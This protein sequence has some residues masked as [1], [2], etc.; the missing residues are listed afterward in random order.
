MQ[1]SSFPKPDRSTFAV[2]QANF[3]RGMRN[4][5]GGNELISIPDGESEKIV[6]KADPGYLV[7]TVRKQAKGILVE[8]E[9]WADANWF[10]D[11]LNY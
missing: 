11:G 8:F 10:E 6:L 9:H 1:K 7:C 5:C 4:I 2:D 3:D